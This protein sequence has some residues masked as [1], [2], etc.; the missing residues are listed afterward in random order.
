MSRDGPKEQVLRDMAWFV[1][2]R[3]LPWPLKVLSVFGETI[4][5]WMGGRA[6][7]IAV[8]DRCDPSGTYRLRVVRA[9]LALLAG[10]FG[11]VGVAFAL[12]MVSE[13]SFAGNDALALALGFCL[14]FLALGAHGALSVHRFRAGITQVAALDRVLWRG[15]LKLAAGVS[16]CF[17]VLFGVAIALMLLREAQAIEPEDAFFYAVAPALFALAAA[18]VAHAHADTLARRKLTSA[19]VAGWSA[20]LMGALCSTSLCAVIAVGALHVK[21]EVIAT[22]IGAA[23]AAA[24]I[25]A[26]LLAIG[27]ATPKRGLV[28]LVK[29]L[30]AATCVA[31]AALILAPWTELVFEPDRFLSRWGF[32]ILFAPFI[33]AFCFCFGIAALL[34][35]AS[36]RLLAAALGRGEASAIARLELC[37]RIPHSEE[38]GLARHNNVRGWQEVR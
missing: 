26:G 30:G 32:G 12:A 11:F 23:H 10:A 16:G 19:N 17:A 9:L 22:G 38:H 13:L 14:L 24:A 31:T 15:G 7:A 5:R 1:G 36:V 18:A 27:A 25:G 6:G 29:A 8:L 4:W 3:Y 35:I 2:F 21:T 28:R 34:S 20:A 33:F 37:D